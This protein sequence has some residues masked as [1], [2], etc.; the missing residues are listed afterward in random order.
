LP[1]AH[2][3]DS[4]QGERF[5]TVEAPDAE[6]AIKVAIEEFGITNPHQQRRLAAQ[7]LW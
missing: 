6:T 2:H 1:L 5:G 7:P 3:L 4:P